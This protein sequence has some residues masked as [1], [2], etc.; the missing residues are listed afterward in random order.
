MEKTIR[1]GLLGGFRGKAFVGPL[2]QQ[3]GFALA[4]IADS[5]E[6]RLEDCRQAFGDG[7]RYM[8]RFEDLLDSDLDA[9]ILADSFHRHA[10]H[11][12]RA[13]E[14]GLDV[15]SETTAAPTLGDCF[16][17]IETAERTGRRYLLAANTA[18]MPGAEEMR[19]VFRS[20]ALGGALYAEAEYLHSLS[21]LT[22]GIERFMPGETHWRRFLP[23]TFYNMHTL[24]VLM[25]I[26]QLTPRRVSAMEAYHAHMAETTLAHK[27]NKSAGGFALYEMEGGAL[28]R[29]GGW[30]DLG[31]DGKWY[32]LTCEYGT[33]ETTRLDQDRILLR[34]S[35]EEPKEYAP[36][37][38][39]EIE[40]TAGHGG[41][42]YRICREICD[43]LSGRATPFFTVY[44]AVA[45]SAAAIYGLYSIL[46]GRTYD[47]PDMKDPVQRRVMQGDYRSPFPDA[48]GTASLPP[49]RYTE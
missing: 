29:S 18:K 1:I 25:H 30:C 35:G 47:I 45:L 40:K 46:D 49:S 20:G 44:H 17:L 21:A 6:G 43:Y 23:G 22:G 36:E 24:G 11:A 34:K 3:E 37:G 28:F 26:T 42:D 39:T 41:A 10:G 48:S 19:R 32:R 12:I 27:K 9:V 33:V 31:P 16:D 4:A 2:S 38:Y 7:I 15:I 5:D 13:M 14:A 8:S